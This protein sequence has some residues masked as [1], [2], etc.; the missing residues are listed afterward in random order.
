MTSTPH[1][2]VKAQVTNDLCKLDESEI[3]PSVN[4][5]EAGVE[6]TD[7]ND[8][9]VLYENDVKADIAQIL[10]PND[11]NEVFVVRDGHESKNGVPEYISPLGIRSW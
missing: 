7:C 8:K 3:A 9:L 5:S 4:K 10:D 11:I 1:K 2:L 6:K